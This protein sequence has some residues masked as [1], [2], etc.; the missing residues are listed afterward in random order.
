MNLYDA[1]IAPDYCIV[2]VEEVKVMDLT[3]YDEL[4][5]EHMLMSRSALQG[6]SIKY[7][8]PALDRSATVLLSRLAAQGPMT[9]AELAEAFGLDVSTVHR[10]V[11]AAMKNGLVQHAEVREKG[12][13]RTHVPTEEG[14]RRLEAEFEG[15]RHGLQRILESW[16]EGKLARFVELMREFNEGVEGLH[17]NFWPRK[18]EP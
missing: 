14:S 6:S 7:R 11:A 9:V 4:A 10:Q 5:Y 2:Q 8:E 16:D 17:G 15:R 1:I 18:R 12:G 3:L 13:A